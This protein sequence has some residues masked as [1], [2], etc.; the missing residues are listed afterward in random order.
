MS[1]FKNTALAD[2]LRRRKNPN[3]FPGASG[4]EVSIR[5]I[6][7][8]GPAEGP[9]YEPELP[10]PATHE[11][12]AASQVPDHPRPG[13]VQAN[14]AQSMLGASAIPARPAPMRQTDIDDAEIEEAREAD[15]Q[16]RFNAGMELAG[17]QL[18][19]GITRTPVPQGLGV[20]PSEVPLAM[21]RA[22]SKREQAAEALRAQRQSTMD[23][24]TLDLQR[25]QAEK[26]RREPGDVPMTPAQAANIELRKTDQ[27][28]RTEENRR[29]AEEAERK[30]VAAV[31]AARA[32]AAEKSKAEGIAAESAKIPFRNGRFVPR[33]GT[34]AD[35]TTARQSM[36]DVKLYSSAD[37]AIDDLNAALSA[38]AKT[39]NAATKDQVT[40]T[41]RGA[42]VALNA[43]YKQGA[44]QG[45]EAAAMR[46]ALGADLASVAGVEAVLMGLMGD[47]SQKS[48]ETIGR[49]AAAVKKQLGNMAMRSMKSANYDYEEDK[50]TGSPGPGYVR[51][52]VD[53]KPGWYNAKTNDWKPD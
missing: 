14:V 31:A 32:K 49:R 16:S 10:P 36:T 25:S 7:S 20:N 12:V 4:D 22:K 51:G 53:G 5:D 26:N 29:K 35:D 30:R 50:P 41:V 40:A 13:S 3:A 1:T 2:A 15:R 8:T 43:A 9:A 37:A 45:D 48:A 24:S 28:L 27:E 17:R 44:M 18:V 47:D 38:W 52:K 19:A 21:A 39:P 6:L 23:A 42:S 34:K 11:T 46:N 33:P